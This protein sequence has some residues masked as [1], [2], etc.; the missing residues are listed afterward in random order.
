[1]MSNNFRIIYLYIVC[2]ITLSMIVGGIVATVSNIVSYIYPDSYV[3]FKDTLIGD[4]VEEKL[5]K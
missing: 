4:E 3:F 1:M 2:F 5:Q